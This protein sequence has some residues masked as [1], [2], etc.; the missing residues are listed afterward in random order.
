MSK[1]ERRELI[2]YATYEDAREAFRSEVLAAKSVR[3]VHLGEHLTLLFENPL[4][5]RYQIQEMMRAE[6][7]VREADIEHELKTYNELLG[8]AG[9]LGATL[10][11]EIVDAAERKDKLA[12][13]WALPE[14]LHLVLADGSRVPASFDQRQR[15][16]GALSSVQYLKF[17]VKGQ[18]PIAAACDLA[19]AAAEARLSDAQRAALADDLALA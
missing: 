11:V 7:L 17:D 8:G 6:R 1:V 19:G 13:W 10:L 9:E 3:R 5:V 15:G 16:D 18:V 14:H 12:R 4:T 2:D